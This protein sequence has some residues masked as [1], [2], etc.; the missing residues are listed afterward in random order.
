VS[1]ARVVS[2]H[3]VR[4]AVGRQA[5]RRAQGFGVGTLVRAPSAPSHSGGFQGDLWTIKRVIRRASALAPLCL[6]ALLT[7]CG[8][9]GG[10]GSNTTASSSPTAA[11]PATAPATTGTTKAPAPPGSTN[12]RATALQAEA[13]SAAAG[14]I[15]D[16][17]VFLTFRGPSGFAIKYPEG[18]AEQASGG[19]VTFR[20]KNN[21]V[22]VIVTPGPKPTVASVRRQLSQLQVA[23]VDS[24]PSAVMIGGERAVKVVYETRSAPNTVTGKRV[25]LVVDRYYLAHSGTVAIVDLGTPQGVDN[26]DAYRL[27]IESF[28]WR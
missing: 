1:G 7:G 9:S 21:V 4:V 27:M 5:T 19:R 2:G 16:N 20:D 10:S 22:R 18:W 13:N 8:S 25:T 15:P 14:D 12:Q 17:Q 3:R 28:R 6:A 11:P 23:R 26:V 24:G